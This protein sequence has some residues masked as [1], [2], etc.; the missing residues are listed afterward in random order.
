[1]EKNVYNRE[2]SI[3]KGAGDSDPQKAIQSQG[4]DDDKPSKITLSQRKFGK[5][6]KKSEHP[7]KKY[8]LKRVKTR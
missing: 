5:F 1:M 2:A 4:T 3:K 8:K 7:L 6:R